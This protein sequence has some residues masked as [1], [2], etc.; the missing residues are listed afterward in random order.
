M[1]EEF[2]TTAA[3]TQRFPESKPGAGSYDNSMTVGA[4]IEDKTGIYLVHDCCSKGME[5]S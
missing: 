4:K 2:N 5:F 3:G 1:P